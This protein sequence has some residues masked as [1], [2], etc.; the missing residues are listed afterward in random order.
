MQGRGS[1]RSFRRA[2]AGPL[3]TEAQPTSAAA[4]IA[5]DVVGYTIQPAAESVRLAN[6][7]CLASQHQESGLKG[8]LRVLLVSQ[9][10]SAPPRQDWHVYEAVPRT[11][12]RPPR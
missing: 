10:A 6:R 11:R 4:E 8:I 2:D 12:S 3:L 9:Q 5:G 7:C 1:D